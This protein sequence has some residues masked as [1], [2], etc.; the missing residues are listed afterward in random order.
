M[1]LQ[2]KLIELAPYKLGC[3]AEDG[4]YLV[5]ITYEKNWSVVPPDNKRIECGGDGDVYY[6]CAP[7]DSVDLNEIFKCIDETIAYNKTLREKLDL[8]KIKVG[9]MQKMF[10]E[11]NLETLKTLTF[12]VKRKKQT[13]ERKKDETNKEKTIEDVSNEEENISATENVENKIQDLEDAMDDDTLN[14]EPTFLEE[15]ER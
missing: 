10:A 2:E 9:E 3:R 7:I 4:F 6:Y 14:V 13:I 12:K 15:V 8:F 1:G 11:E 5:N